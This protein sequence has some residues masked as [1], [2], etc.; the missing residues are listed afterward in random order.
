[1][2]PPEVKVFGTMWCHQ[3]LSAL[4]FLEE[5]GIYF[6]WIDIDCSRE[7][8]AFV[9]EVNDGYRSVP[10][11]LLKDGST[12]TEPTR[13]ELVREFLPRRRS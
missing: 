12:L 9:L 10:T 4:D 2:N 6:E 3:A 11:I 7:G 13:Q 1:M 5:H 8:E